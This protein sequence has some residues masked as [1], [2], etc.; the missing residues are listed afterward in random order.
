MTIL[1]EQA[2]LVRNT[3]RGRSFGRSK[4]D[5][6]IAA[7]VADRYSADRI[8]SGRYRKLL[9]SSEFTKTLGEI[10]SKSYEHHIANTLPWDDKG[11]RILPTMHYFEY[12]AVQRNLR[13][14]FR[15]AA[16]AFE[17]QYQEAVEESKARLGRMFNAADY[18][19]KAALFTKHSETGEYLRFGI[20]DAGT[21]IVVQPIPE[22]PDF[23]VQLNG[24]ETAR[25]KEQLETRMQAVLTKAVDDLWTR[26]PTRVIALRDN[27][28]GYDNNERV[29]MEAA[30]VDNLKDVVQLLPKLN[31]T[32]DD[33]LNQI[34][35]EAEMMLTQWNAAQLKASPATRT[36]VKD[37][38]SEIL[39]KMAD[40]TGFLALGPDDESAELEDAA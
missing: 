10:A 16:Q 12:M 6:Q 19:D 1:T 28:E 36:F 25:L 27:L 33:K 14:Q 39:A 8:K 40:Y 9:I 3:I 38:A 4:G 11:W 32:G 29:K 34:C 21:G 24:M 31:F 20:G 35:R 7:E 2:V 37:R 5:K 23:R 13:D 22:G 18:Q 30:W 17:E 26:L 15:D